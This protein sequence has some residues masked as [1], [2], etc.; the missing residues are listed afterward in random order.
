MEVTDTNIMRTFFR[1]QLFCPV[2]EGVAKERSHVASQRNKLA[3][4]GEL[5]PALNCNLGTVIKQFFSLL[6]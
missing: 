4:L 5:P 3:S 2:N 6:K 1:D